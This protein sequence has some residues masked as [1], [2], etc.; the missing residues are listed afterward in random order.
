M[1]GG[2]G[3][4]AGSATLLERLVGDTGEP[5]KVVTSA[6]GLGERMAKAVHAALAESFGDAPTLE[7]DAV[8]V[9]RMASLLTR[10]GALD[11]AVMGASPLSADALALRIDP[12]AAAMLLNAMFGAGGSAAVSPIEREFSAIELEAANLV[13]RLF[14]QAFNGAAARAVHVRVPLPAALTGQDLRKMVVRDGPAVRLDYLVGP[15]QDAGR[16]TVLLPQRILMRAA[17]GAELEAVTGEASGEWGARFGEEVMR[18]SVTLEAT[19]P[20]GRMTLGAI[21]S[22]ERGQVIELPSEAPQQARL[23][24]RDKMLFVCE[25]GRLGQHY[26]VRIRG[27][28]DASGEQAERSAS[29]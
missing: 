3:G 26:T 28:I 24:A 6:Q 1:A 12:M 22:L 25:F 14:A 16:I 4:T 11:A 7:L 21:A 8:E 9:D 10:A 13:F 23:S 19:M 2:V 27:S 17:A 15:K 18:A 29:S 20:L 5:A